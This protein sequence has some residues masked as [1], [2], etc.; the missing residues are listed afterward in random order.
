M[1]HQGAL[2]VERMILESLVKK[3]K[4]LHL[5]SEDTG[6]EENLL[7]I[8]LQ[9]MIFKG[10]LQ[11]RAGEYLLCETGEVNWIKE[12][13]REDNLEGEVKELMDSMVSLHFKHQSQD[14]HAHFKIQ[15]L[16]LTEDEE[17]LLNSHLKGLEIFF[18]N[19]RH[20]RM[21]KPLKGQTKKQK[22]V[23]WGTGLYEDL[24]GANLVAV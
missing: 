20:S 9:E 21:K 4:N 19:V 11:F 7:K 24:V 13:N 6:I 12:I 10:W 18:K 23:V 15:K 8:L 5:L 1:G 16:E 3:N 17:K 2:L 14:P 22:V